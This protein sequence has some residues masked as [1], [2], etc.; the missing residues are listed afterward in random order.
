MDKRLKIGFRVDAS[1][2]IGTGHLMEV[3]ALIEALRKKIDFAPAVVTTNNAFTIEKLRDHEI[4]QIIY[5]PWELREEA[6]A[7]QLVGDLKDIGCEHLVVDLLHRSN[8]YY[9]YLNSN[10]KTTCVILDNSEHKETPASLV[11]NFSITQDPDFYRNADHHNTKYLIGPRYFCFDEVIRGVESVRTVGQKVE[12]VF[13][14]QG[15]SDPYGLTAKILRAVE[16][17]NFGQEFHIVLGGLINAETRSE[18]ETLKKSFAKANYKFYSDLPKSSLYALMGN[19]DLAVSA[20]GNTLYE[21]LFI[22]VPTLV[23]SHHQAHDQVAGAFAQKNAVVNLGIGTC[24]GE[25]QIAAA[26]KKL[27]DEE[28]TRTTLQQNAQRLFKGGPN[29]SLADELTRLYSR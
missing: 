8:D 19:A 6:E 14:N 28:F 2:T 11:V 24:L 23:I 15:G 4:R 26:I 18:V 25:A 27:M 10:L 20:A 3:I 1:N 7:E 9:G 12:R 22:G 17:G 16:L 21:L 5:L 29:D 13:V